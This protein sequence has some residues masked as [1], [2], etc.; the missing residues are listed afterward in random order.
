MS[1]WLVEETD[2]VVVATYHNPPMNYMTAPA[3]VE[4]AELIEDW[5]REEVRAVILTGGVQGKFITHYSVEELVDIAQ[6]PLEE[7]LETEQGYQEFV[8]GLRKLPK[9]VIMAM[10]GDTMGGGFE[11]CMG[12]D[13]RIAQQGDHRIGLPEVRLGILPGGAGTQTLPR[14]IGLA[15]ASEFILRGRA[16]NPDTALALGLVHEV[17]E[18]ALKRAKIVA[19]DM[20]D[21]VT[22]LSIA[23]AK[24]ALYDGIALSIEDGCGVERSAFSATM[25]SDSGLAVM[26]DYTS[27]P[28]A[29]RRDSL[30]SA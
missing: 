20:V 4:L 18:D 28:F 29:A 11:L 15:K 22:P 19:R 25:V 5:H 6:G 24:R 23:E 2:G 8:L 21:H 7:L 26:R 13:I 16:V 10:N 1:L 30:E 9:P 14:L 12:A 3:V 17:S 27:L